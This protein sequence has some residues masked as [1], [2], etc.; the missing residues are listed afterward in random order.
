MH[1]HIMSDDL[2]FLKDTKHWNQFDPNYDY[3]IQLENVISWFESYAY[4][5]VR[6]SFILY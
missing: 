5:N 4:K 2:R 1:L 6:I 3:F